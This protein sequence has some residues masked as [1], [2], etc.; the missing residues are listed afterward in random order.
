MS[1]PSKSLFLVGALLALAGA[2]GQPAPGGNPAASDKEAHEHYLIAL[3]ALKHNDLKEAVIQLKQAATLAPN[4]AEI[5]YNIAVVESQQGHDQDALDTLHKAEKLGLPA[6][7]QDAVDKLEAKLAYA[8]KKKARVAAATA[9]QQLRQQVIEV[10]IS[11]LQNSG[12]PNGLGVE[13]HCKNPS[14]YVSYDTLAWMVYYPSDS[15]KPDSN[16]LAVT[17]VEFTSRF[18]NGPNAHNYLDQVTR[19]IEIGLPI[20]N[21]D[22]SG[23]EI[24]VTTSD[25]YCK[26]E[27]MTS[28]DS[29]SAYWVNIPAKRPVSLPAY[30]K[31]WHRDYWRKKDDESTVRLGGSTSVFSYLFREQS[32]ARTFLEHV[33]ELA[34]SP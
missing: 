18:S 27:E 5:W 11:D 33:K 29:G 14:H 20:S 23:A 3:E 25:D 26:K 10:L 30:R 6:T 19:T 4:N 15:I 8:A 22:L 9:I 21:L 12:G 28:E 2:S 13:F 16:S 1:V 32:Q 17:V 24:S 34:K 7:K 31:D